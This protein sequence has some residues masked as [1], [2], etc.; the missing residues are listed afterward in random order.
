M[1]RYQIHIGLTAGVTCQHRMLTQPR[2]LTPYTYIIC[3]GPCKPDLYCGLF[4]LPDLDTDLD[5]GCSVYLTEHTDFDC[6]LFHFPDLDTPI[7]TIEC[8]A[9]NGAHDRGCL[10]L[11]TWFYLWFLQGSM[12]AQFSGFVFHTGFMRLITVRYITCQFWWEKKMTV[13]WRRRRYT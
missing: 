6:G 13:W 9:L 2:H 12:F 5:C 7:L 10:L 8:C 4:H 1:L 11:D 3:R